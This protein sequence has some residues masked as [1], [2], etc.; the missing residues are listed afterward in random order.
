MSSFASI[1]RIADAENASQGYKRHC[2]LAGIA[3]REPMTFQAFLAR[4]GKNWPT[5]ATPQAQAPTSDVDERIAAL[6]AELDSL[7]NGGNAAAASQ[8]DAMGLVYVSKRGG[9]EHTI[10]RVDGE[11]AYSD[12]GLTFKVASLLK[13]RDRGHVDG[14]ANVR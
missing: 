6:Q 12:T 2:A 14:K 5:D 7:R 1:G 10:V 8:E 3:K 13:I 4:H 11:S 9:R